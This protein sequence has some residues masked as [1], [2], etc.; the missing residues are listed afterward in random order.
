MTG[1]LN[2]AAAAAREAWSA[3]TLHGR[4]LA[5]R[6]ADRLRP[7]HDFYRPH[8]TRRRRPFARKCADRWRRVLA[9]RGGDRRR[10]VVAAFV[11]S[12]RD[13]FRHALAQIRHRGA[14]RR[15]SP[16]RGRRN[17]AGVRR[18]RPFCA[19]IARHRGAR[20]SGNG[21]RQCAK[22]RGRDFFAR[23]ADRQCADRAVEPDRRRD[24]VAHRTE[25]AGQYPGG[26]R[27]ARA[28]RQS[29]RHELH[30]NRVRRRP[31][32]E[33]RKPSA[34]RGRRRSDR[35]RSSPGSTSSTLS[36]SMAARSPRSG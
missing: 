14:A 36:G 30:R 10:S 20:R 31:F 17:G 22:G 23:P 24:G 27:Q 4:E 18:G 26:R 21:D 15:Q 34:G 13:R 32:R 19:A 11:W 1:F 6:A 8:L 35:R 12:D 28:R 33:R 2:S 3:L 16:G 25:R 9:C 7:E 5:E 29:G